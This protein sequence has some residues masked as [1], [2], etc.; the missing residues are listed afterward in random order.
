MV[1]R[2]R[3]KF[4]QKPSNCCLAAFSYLR[5][6]SNMISVASPISTVVYASNCSSVKYIRHHLLSESDET[7][8]RII[9]I[10]TNSL[11]YFFHF[12]KCFSQATILG[13]FHRQG[14][15]YTECPLFLQ[16][17]PTMHRNSILNVPSQKYLRMFSFVVYWFIV[18]QVHVVPQL[19]PFSGVRFAYPSSSN[20]L[21]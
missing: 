11:F 16:Q 17:V 1:R 2:L 19:V 8:Q 3:R 20:A 7:A 10:L 9:L 21:S 13:R 5:L 12:C 4:Q 15:A 14:H 18:Y 6:S